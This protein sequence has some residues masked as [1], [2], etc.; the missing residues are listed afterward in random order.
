VAVPMAPPHVFS[1]PI[2]MFTPQARRVSHAKE[3]KVTVDGC[4]GNRSFIVARALIFAGLI[5]G[6]A[7]VPS[8]LSA[9]DAILADACNGESVLSYP[10]SHRFVDP[11]APLSERI[12]RVRIT[13]GAGPL[14]AAP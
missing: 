6:V 10:G 4:S 5:L 2:V 13:L 7:G 11:D 12:V 9:P 14:T 1:R 3:E 8:A